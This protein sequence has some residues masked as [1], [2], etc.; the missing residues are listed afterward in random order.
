MK[1]SNH[2]YSSTGN[3]FLESWVNALLLREIL[4]FCFQKPLWVYYF[5]AGRVVSV[6]EQEIHAAT[7]N[8]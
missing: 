6:L 5:F 8:L 2:R 3:E 7:H 4:T 1:T